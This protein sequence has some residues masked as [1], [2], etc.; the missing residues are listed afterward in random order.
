MLKRLLAG[1]IPFGGVFAFEIDQVLSLRIGLQVPVL[2]AYGAIAAHHLKA[3]ERWEL[4]FVLDGPT[5]AICFV[6]DFW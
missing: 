3:L 4:D 6:L 2:G 1:E 5:V